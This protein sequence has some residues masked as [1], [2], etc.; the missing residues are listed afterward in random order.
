MG[1]D[2]SSLF[3][4][5]KIIAP[6]LV[7]AAIFLAN[8]YNQIQELE[9]SVIPILD[10]EY[11]EMFVKDVAN[12]ERYVVCSMYMYKLDNNL[13]GELTESVPLITEAFVNA[14]KRNVTVVM[15][16]EHR[17]GEDD[18]INDMNEKT[19]KYLRDNGIQV[20]FDSDEKSMNSKM[21]VIDEDIVYIGSHNFT[22]SSL[23]KHS[24][25]GV[26]LRSAETASKFKGYINRL[27]NAEKE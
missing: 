6:M 16:L 17:D 20:F 21:C 19:A 8:A 10:D 27:V 14:A 2:K 13:Q 25:A 3:T 11:T 15:V 7:V 18:F 23:N 4:V 12:A 26:R 9:T 5:L 22:Y 1:K 24:E